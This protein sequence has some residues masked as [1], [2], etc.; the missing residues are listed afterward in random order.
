MNRFN[1]SLGMV[2][3][4][5]ILLSAPGCARREVPDA[6]TRIGQAWQDFRLSEYASAVELFGAVVADAS[7]GQAAR[8]EAL[9]G[10]AEIWRTRLS[11]TDVAKAKTLYEQAIGVCPTN[12]IAAW[13]S[14]AMARMVHVGKG[15]E[16]A[17]ADVIA[18]YEDVVRR[19]PDHPAGEE[20]CL[21]IHSVRLCLRT[22]NEVLAAK[23]DIERFLDERPG[24]PFRSL[25]FSLKAYTHEFLGQQEERMRALI[26]SLECAERDPLSP[27][28]DFSVKYWVIAT[29]AEF[30]VGDFDVAR[31]Y[32]K[33][34]IEEQPTDVRVFM[35]KQALERLDRITNSE[36]SA[37]EGVTP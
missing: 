10:M 24:S 6:A 32:Y 23:A 5:A 4:A 28:S 20:A 30:D 12:D 2:Y 7:A 34:L 37:S 27:W 26:Q 15:D 25:A 22:S 16:P 13:S 11:G 14:L 1:Q 19:F 18:A 33:R 21:H 35:A 3:V 17:G 31:K 9:Y 36:S 29:V 8:Q